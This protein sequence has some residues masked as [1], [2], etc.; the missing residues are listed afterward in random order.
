MFK[1]DYIYLAYHIVQWYRMQNDALS[2]YHCQPFFIR[3]IQ[4]STFYGILELCQTNF[5]TYVKPLS[6]A[7]FGGPRY[8]G[9]R[10]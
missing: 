3:H 2:I 10:K 6:Q 1:K 9:P 4:I 8:V 7:Y 5:R